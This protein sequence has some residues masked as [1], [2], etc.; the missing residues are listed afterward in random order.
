ML[1]KRKANIFKMPRVGKNLIGFSDF[2]KDE[3]FEKFIQLEAVRILHIQQFYLL[4]LVW[5]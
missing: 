4:L 2:K 5:L 1:I 3:L